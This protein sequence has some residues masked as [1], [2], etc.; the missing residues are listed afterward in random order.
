MLEKGSRAW[1]RRGRG[2]QQRELPLRL[3]ARRRPFIRSDQGVDQRA[4]DRRE[5]C[6][7]ADLRREHVA[8]PK[9]PRRR[10]GAKGIEA[11]EFRAQ[12]RHRHRRG[13]G[14]GGVL[15]GPLGKRLGARKQLRRLGHRIEPGGL[16]L[17][18]LAARPQGGDV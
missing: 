14:F 15:L 10:L 5:R 13:F 6:L 18:E 2:K 7:V 9:K 17:E 8:E 16:L 11:F 12:A 1:L 4:Q 3:R